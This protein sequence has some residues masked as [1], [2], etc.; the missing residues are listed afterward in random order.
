ME[1]RDV[2][3]CESGLRLLRLALRASILI[4]FVVREFVL[5]VSAEIAATAFQLLLFCFFKCL[6]LEILDDKFVFF[7]QVVDVLVGCSVCILLQIV[8]THQLLAFQLLTGGFLTDF[9]ER[10][11][12]EMSLQI[13]LVFFN[14]IGDLSLGL[15][16]IH[17]NVLSSFIFLRFSFTACGFFSELAHDGDID[18][19]RN[20]DAMRNLEPINA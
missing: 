15:I 19:E 2:F 3:L 18:A 9:N 8:S 20:I 7:L 11:L 13:L 1:L 12:N 14:E 4:P 10:I 17:L 5:G 6:L 16:T